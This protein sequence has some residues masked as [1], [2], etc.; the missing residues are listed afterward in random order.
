MIIN[1]I[2]QTLEIVEI[3]KNDIKKGIQIN[4][5]PTEFSNINSLNEFSKTQN[6]FKLIISKCLDQKWLP[7]PEYGQ[8]HYFIF[9]SIKNNKMSPN[10]IKISYFPDQN[11][12]KKSN[13]EI[14]FEIYLNYQFHDSKMLQGN[15]SSSFLFNFQHIADIRQI[16][17]YLSIILIVV[18]KKALG[19]DKIF[20]ERYFLNEIIST[21]EL[22]KNFQN[23]DKSRSFQVSL[24][25]I[26]FEI[27]AGL[28]SNFDKKQITCM[29]IEKQFTAFEYDKIMNCI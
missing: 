4:N 20:T 17:P 27:D 10:Q 2:N 11:I 12:M 3:K 6:Q 19:K 15:V 18:C 8:N 26:K 1:S 7:I 22:M 25:K 24:N 9:H 14:Y 21:G 5:E 28:N 13:Y 16:I 29:F 23:P